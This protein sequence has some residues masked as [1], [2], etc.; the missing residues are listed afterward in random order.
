MKLRSALASAVLGALFAGT[1]VLSGCGGG[2]TSATS[3]PTMNEQG[4]GGNAAAS[5]KTGVV[6]F[7]VKWPT[8]APS[9]VIPL[10]TQNI[11]VRLTV[12]D[13][14]FADGTFVRDVTIPVG[15]QPAPISG[16]PVGAAK[17]EV[18]ALGAASPGGSSTDLLAIYSQTIL[19]SEGSNSPAV[20][21][22]AASRFLQSV[23]LI[24]A[25]G[26][27]PVPVTVSFSGGRE[28]FT[29]NSGEVYEI[30]LGAKTMN[31]TAI[32]LPVA[33]VTVSA[34][35]GGL[36]LLDLNNVPISG[37]SVTGVTSFRIKETGAFSF[38]DDFHIDVPSELVSGSTGFPFTFY[39]DV[40]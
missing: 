8:V 11:R 38:S 29:A 22:E 18:S 10:A 24:P 31:G 27:A 17:M 6:Q 5:R 14:P 13:V 34:P 25:G 36:Q 4:N 33:Q 20:N 12:Y 23:Q 28:S 2:N 16:V 30:T 19:V 3:A 15:T 40:Y 7:S 1:G 35:H 39:L 32:N 9:R 21:L 26:G 37:N